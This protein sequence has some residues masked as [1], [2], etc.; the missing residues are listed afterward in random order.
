MGPDR[1]VLTFPVSHGATLNL[2]AFVTSERDWPSDVSLTLPATQE[3]ALE[4]FKDFG[5]SVLGLI[6]LC[7]E[8]PDRVRRILCRVEH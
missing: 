4:D 5:P 1:H 2:V 7:R 8:K 6:K 3:E